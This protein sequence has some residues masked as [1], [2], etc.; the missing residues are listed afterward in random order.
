MANDLQDQ[1]ADAEQFKAKGDTFYQNKKFEQAFKVYEIAH[2]LVKDYCQDNEGKLRQRGA[3]LMRVNQLRLTVLM[4]LVESAF[5]LAWYEE[6]IVF[7]QQGIE[8]N[9]EIARL[10]HM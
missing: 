1:L 2:D 10:H 6:A 3:E 5:Q 9:S 4:A 7:C 8:I